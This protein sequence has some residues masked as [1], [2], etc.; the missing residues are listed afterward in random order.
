[1]TIG[2]NSY[3]FKMT[4]ISIMIMI[5]AVKHNYYQYC[6]YFLIVITLCVL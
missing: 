5:L 2:I 1:M 6:D 4:M 3:D